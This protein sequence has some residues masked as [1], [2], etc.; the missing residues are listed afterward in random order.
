MFFTGA[1]NMSV[2]GCT[3]DLSDGGAPD[4]RRIVAKHQ[5]TIAD[6]KASAEVLCGMG[7]SATKPTPWCRAV[8][9]PN[10]AVD[11]LE[12]PGLVPITS[13]DVQA[14]KIH[15]D[16]T[17]R[18]L[19]AKLAAASAEERPALQTRCGFRH[20][21]NNVIAHPSLDYKPA[22][23]LL[24]DWMHVWCIDGVF[25]RTMKSVM[26]TLRGACPTGAAPT[27]ADLDTVMR[28]YTWPAQHASARRVFESG[29]DA[30]AGSASQTLAAAPVLRKY[31]S[32]VILPMGYCV[33]E[34]KL[35]LAACDMLGACV[36]ASRGKLYPAEFERLTFDFMREYCRLYNEDN[37]TLKFHL[38]MEMA[39]QWVR[40]NKVAEKAKQFWK[41]PNCFALERKHKASKKHMQDH[42]SAISYERTILEEIFLDMLDAWSTDRVDGLDAAYTPSKA[43]LT[44]LQEHHNATCGFVV[45]RTYKA[46]SGAQFA[47]KDFVWTS[48]GNAGFL[49]LLYGFD[50]AEVARVSVWQE[51]RALPD[52]TV[53]HYRATGAKITIPCAGLREAGVWKR[54]RD[55]CCVLW[56][57]F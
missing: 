20:V 42:L 17:M 22:S 47:R 55:I 52:Y 46:S 41:L 53:C 15:T 51:V 32:D 23:T 27:A 38:A 4:I 49:E 16:A 5:I 7:V 12:A 19:I 14:W 36:A 6:Y 31:F 21:P 18:A 25:D 10:R 37:Y 2:T 34:V 43:L 39:V 35:L 48:C 40:L 54:S 9:V 30:P 26:S 29:S 56:H 44:E 28:C 13:T 50:G 11:R 3:V 8:V 24:W 57:K 1:S 45:S 33:D